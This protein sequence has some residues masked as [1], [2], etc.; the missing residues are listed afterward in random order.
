M[1]G[2][3]AV[4]VAMALWC[5][6]IVRN[7]KPWGIQARRGDVARALEAMSPLVG[8]DRP[9]LLDVRARFLKDVVEVFT[10]WPEVGVDGDN[11]QSCVQDPPLAFVQPLNPEALHW[12]ETGAPAYKILERWGKLE[13]VPDS[14]FCLGPGKYKI[15][16][17]L[18]WDKR[19]VTVS[20]PPPPESGLV[21]PPDHTLLRLQ[22]PECAAD[23][24]VRV[25]LGG[26]LLAE[27]LEPGYQFLGVP[28]EWLETPDGED[29]TFELRIEAD[30]P[31]PDDFHPAW[32]HP[33]SPLEMEFGA[34]REPSSVS[35]LSEEFRQY[36]GLSGLD[37]EYPY[38]PAPTIARE[39]AG[40]GEI[41]LPDGVGEAGAEYL[42]RMSFQTLH[43][44]LDGQLAVTVSVPE[45]PEVTP[46]TDSK[47]FLTHLQ[48][49]SFD[50]G[51][52]PGPPHA[53]R[54]HADC[55]VEFPESILGNPRHADIQLGSLAVIVRRDVDA[56]AVS[57]GNSGDGVLLGEGFFGRERADT[58]KHGRWTKS[59]AEAYL[60]LKGG[61]DYRLELVF[62][63]Y[64]PESVPP[65]VPQVSLNGHLVETEPTENGVA[66]RIEGGWLDS[67]NSLVIE[68]DTWCPAE[69]GLPDRRRFGIFLRDILVRPFEGP[70]E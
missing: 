68:S 8:E 60:P 57:V 42:V 46:V 61:Q 47:P 6:G 13:E 11:A 33:D 49:F 20:L 64:R 53:L 22:V 44:D 37:S 5:R 45:Y 2:W 51:E 32:L 55:D 39:F 54:I 34:I 69:H 63:Q 56:L 9:V 43:H 40:D 26:R 28:R 27:R 70:A 41:R 14:D 25:S 15:L 67:T 4:W 7:I 66:G 17:V 52:L 36:D 59:R 1:A 62:S 16:R 35:Y 31:I 10:D 23:F 3:V 19:S 29:G 50:L 18:K 12:A 65:A 24:P 58:P 38:W 48:T 30:E 21:P